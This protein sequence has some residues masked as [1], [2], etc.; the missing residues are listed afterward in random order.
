V[1]DAGR[2]LAAGGFPIRL[3]RSRGRPMP[4]TVD[5]PWEWPPVAVGSAL[6]DPRGRALTV[7]A[8]FGVAAAPRRAAAYGRPGPWADEVAQIEAA[9]GTE[10]T[11]HVSLE[12]FART[13]TSRR[14]TLER[15]REGGVA[16]GDARRRASSGDGAAER[17]AWVRA[18]RRFRALDRP[19][20]LHLM[21]VFDPSA[22]F[23]REFPEIVQVGPLWPGHPPPGPRA[24]RPGPRQAL[25]YA[26]PSSSTYILGDL[27]R[28]IGP[29]APRW[30]LGIR[31]PRP[32]PLPPDAPSTVRLLSPLPARLWRP[33][34]AAA[35]LR[36]VTGSRSLLEA[37][38]L[39]GPFL[40]F[41]GI[42]RRAG[43]SR[44]HRPEKIAGLLR[45][46]GRLGVAERVRRDLDAFSR[47][48]RTGEVLL[49]ALDDPGW[50]GAFPSP[51]RVRA[52]TPPP[53]ASTLLRVARAFARGE[54]TASA[55]VAR[56]RAAGRRR[57]VPAAS[58]V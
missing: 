50:R 5:G 12:E 54:A 20:V 31:S 45:L 38:E 11:L 2:V 48:H 24:V 10:H 25:W 42:L 36:I 23:A 13:Y 53:L 51:A 26:S 27:L 28:A 57:V 39:G 46:F 55:L 40:Y 34:F 52:A 9:Y 1:L 7:S 29:L 15:F 49:R 44:R 16:A 37:L 19:N 6:P 17:A 56:E 47:G 35:G 3:F 32:L 30:E 4:P 21:G 14:E 41:N 8:T 58:K 33:R 18:F 43:S 22:R